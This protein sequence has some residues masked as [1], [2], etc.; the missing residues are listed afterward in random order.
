M[1]AAAGY[2]GCGGCCWLWR[3]LVDAAAVVDAAAWWMRVAMAEAI[4]FSAITWREGSHHIGTCWLDFPPKFASRW[5]LAL[6][7]CGWP[8]LGRLRFFRLCL[9]VVFVPVFFYL[10]PVSPLVCFPAIVALCR[11]LQG[12]RALHAA[13][14]WLACGCCLLL[15][16]LVLLLLS[17]LFVVGLAASAGCCCWLLLL[18]PVAVASGGCC[19]CCL[20]VAVVLAACDC[21]CCWCRCWCCCCPFLVLFL[22]LSF[23]LFP[24]LL[25]AL[26]LSLS[27]SLSLWL[28]VLSVLSS[29]FSPSL[30]VSVS[31]LSDLDLY[32]L[33]RPALSL[34]TAPDWS[35]RIS[36]TQSMTRSMNAIWINEWDK[37]VRNGGMMAEYLIYLSWAMVWYILHIVQL[38]PHRQPQFFFEQPCRKQPRSHNLYGNRS[39]GPCKEF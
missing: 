12:P 36:L 28:F 9:L 37:Q 31:I 35:D 39:K 6:G 16:L 10:F 22:L 4:G 30:F 17:L 23:A 20:P 7:C 25:L 21:S 13:A 34:L 26:S 8:W 19:C 29:L 3:L 18:L 11:C 38:Q 24:S 15:L 1:A 27:C 14:P 5:D 32:S 2:G 33:A